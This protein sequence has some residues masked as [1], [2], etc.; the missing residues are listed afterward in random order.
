MW[1]YAISLFLHVMSALAFATLLGLEWVGLIGLRHAA[2][3]ERARIWSG[4]LGLRRPGACALLTLLLTGIQLSFTGWGAP[5][6]LL[7]GLAATAAIAFLGALGVRRAAMVQRVL[8]AASGEI[9]RPIARRLH[10]PAFDFSIRLRTA[11][12]LGVVFVMVDKPGTAGALG[13]IGVSALLGLIVGPTH[14]TPEV[15]LPRASR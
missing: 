15:P 14:R 8:A 4:L 6:W 2:S 13:A 3:A 1:L 9:P 10:D 5:A 11:L 7:V 12:L